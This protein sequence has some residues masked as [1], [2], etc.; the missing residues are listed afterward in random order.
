MS[1]PPNLPIFLPI[2][3]SDNTDTKLMPLMNTFRGDIVPA[4]I[5]YT[6]NTIINHPTPFYILCTAKILNWNGIPNIPTSVGGGVGVVT[7]QQFGLAAGDPTT[8]GPTDASGTN[9]ADKNQFT[10][11]T[12]TDSLTSSGPDSPGLLVPVYCY[13]DPAVSRNFTSTPAFGF[14][15]ADVFWDDP[16]G[17]T[18]QSY[19]DHL[20]PRPKFYK[21]FP[22][23]FGKNINNIYYLASLYT[24]VWNDNNRMGTW[25]LFATQAQV[26][27]INGANPNWK[28][29]PQAALVSIAFNDPEISNSNVNILRTS[30]IYTV[31]HM[32]QYN[33][34]SVYWPDPYANQPII[35]Y[36]DH[37]TSPEY[38]GY[39]LN[40]LYQVG[41][42]ST[43]KKSQGLY[44][45]YYQDNSINYQGTVCQTGLPFQGNLCINTLWNMAYIADA[46]GN[47]YVF[48]TNFLSN[49]A[50][51]SVRYECIC[52]SGEYNAACISAS[53]TIASSPSTT[54]EEYTG[55][56]RFACNNVFAG[57]YQNVG[58]QFI[59]IDFFNVP[60]K[61]FIPPIVSSLGPFEGPTG[62]EY[63]SEEG[64]PGEI[65][66]VGVI[67]PSWPTAP[68][69]SVLPGPPAGPTGAGD[70]ILTY[71][72]NGATGAT[73]NWPDNVRPNRFIDNSLT[74][75]ISNWIQN[76]DVYV[77][78]ELIGNQEYCMFQDYY[79]SLMGFFYNRPQDLV[80]GS[81]CGQDYIPSEINYSTIKNPYPVGGCTGGDVCVP[82]YEYLVDPT[83]LGVKP[84]Y[85]Q[86]PTGT[87]PYPES[88]NGFNNINSYPI[89]N[90]DNVPGLTEFQP[91]TGTPITWENLYTYQNLTPPAPPATPQLSFKQVPY[92]NALKLAQN[93]NVN[94]LTGKTQN[95]KGPST[96][97]IVIIVII[98]LV[99][100]VIVIIVL[101]RSS[102]SKSM[103]IYNPNSSMFYQQVT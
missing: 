93:N 64:F 99:V 88:L 78:P 39:P 56:F 3:K 90:Y 80:A 43:Y 12:F 44:Q 28:T 94:Q 72:Y 25:S 79:H 24:F 68:T 49:G 23:P 96:L 63:Y 20:P 18:Y 45:T 47:S 92:I 75:V 51:Q 21:D 8:F 84:F 32:N 29:G 59:P 71:P 35:E 38:G 6:T 10:L 61:S 58:F 14:F 60:V 91:Q 34:S 19:I 57:T 48:N 69:G 98:I 87:N 97:I 89:Y 15:R 53:N 95:Q 100:V 11:T 4:I 67:G 36:S 77:C 22:T 86:N 41:S 65:G 73:N 13:Q 55:Y 103:D 76:P 16:A 81:S 31:K 102:N 33:N 54:Y 27:A 66:P 50:V 101:Y 2:I 46:Y 1:N 83:A 82:N 5:D 42:P 7:F 85:C 17:P 9:Y 70:Y 52:G 26:D 30:T 40:F 74:Q 62:S 37:S